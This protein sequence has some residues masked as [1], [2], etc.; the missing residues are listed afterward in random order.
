MALR[1]T[2]PDG[3]GAGHPYSS[4]RVGEGPI[5]W[6]SG[7]VPHDDRGQLVRDREG[8]VDQC[9]HNLAQRLA[10]AGAGLGDVVRTTVYLTDLSWRDA[11]DAAYARVFSPP[12][13][14]R[15]C[16][17]V[18]ALPRGSDIEID[19]VVQVQG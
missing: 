18:R 9:L 16:V 19:A 3:L 8:A 12:M 6:V 11:V 7:V 10:N 1:T 2:H 5:G 15:T 4:V 14:A 13:P 17:E